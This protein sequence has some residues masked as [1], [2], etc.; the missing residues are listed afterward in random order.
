MKV[1]RR[2]QALT[3]C[4][5]RQLLF[6]SR[7]CTVHFRLRHPGR[8]QHGSHAFKCLP[9]LEN[10]LDFLNPEFDDE[11]TTIMLHPNEA[12]PFKLADGFA[13]RSSAHA[14]AITDFLLINLLA[15]K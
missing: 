1:C 5:Q 14:K 2:R 13:Y 12:F 3:S 9:G 15:W 4:P 6:Q 11:R 7:A 10:V 8:S